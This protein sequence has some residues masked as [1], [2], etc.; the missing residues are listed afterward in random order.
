L[1]ATL[2]QGIDTSWKGH[3]LSQWVTL[4]EAA[5]TTGLTSEAI[6]NWATS[7]EPRIRARRTFVGKRPI[8]E[9]NSDDVAREAAKSRRTVGS[10]A[11]L[12]QGIEGGRVET[13]EDVT[14]IY[15]LIDELRS[16]IEE[17]HLEIERLQREIATVLQAPSSLEHLPM[18]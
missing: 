16:Q 5:A 1:L 7:S 18:A 12:R 14:R 8:W 9:V 2:G 4:S 6:R 3:T 17:R 11:V 15:R 10:R 13:L